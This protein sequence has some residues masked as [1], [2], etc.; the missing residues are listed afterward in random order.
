[1]VYIVLLLKPAQ[2]KNYSPGTDQPVMGV[3]NSARPLKQHHK[4]INE[5]WIDNFE[6][7]DGKS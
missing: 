1:V 2:L 5:D 6:L 7:S 3:E 4:P